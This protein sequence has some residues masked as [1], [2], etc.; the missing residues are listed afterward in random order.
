MK[1]LFIISVFV[2]GIA[3]GAF[4]YWFVL[5]HNTF[6]G[7]LALFVVVMSLLLMLGIV[8]YIDMSNVNVGLDLPGGMTSVVY[9]PEQI[10]ASFSSKF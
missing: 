4:I 8:L 6:A 3:L 7:R 5:N 2:S 10:H 1:L 9:E